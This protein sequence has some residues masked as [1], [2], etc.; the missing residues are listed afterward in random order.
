MSTTM[1]SVILNTVATAK[2]TWLIVIP[3]TPSAIA[4]GKALGSRLI[5]PYLNERSTTSMVR[6]IPINAKIDPY[7]IERMLFSPIWVNIIVRLEPGVRKCGAL[8][9]NHC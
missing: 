5:K 1:P 7:I 8:S 4:A 2:L 9:M 3:Q 6:V